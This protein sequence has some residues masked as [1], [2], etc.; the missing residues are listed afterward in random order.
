MMTRR[1]F[2]KLVGATAAAATFADV[3]ALVPVP[4]EALGVDWGAGLDWTAYHRVG[5]GIKAGVPHWWVD[6]RVA[7]NSPAIVQ[8][9]SRIISS[10]G[11]AG[12][13]SSFVPSRPDLQPDVEH[14]VELGYQEHLG[15]R[16]G[17]AGRYATY[18]LDGH[19]VAGRLPEEWGGIG[20]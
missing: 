11:I 7:N 9:L 5:L 10:H 4:A 17:R 13:E 12:A 16:H 19:V 3:A 20:L 2:F 8:K 6:G 15:A 1:D 18:D 14:Y